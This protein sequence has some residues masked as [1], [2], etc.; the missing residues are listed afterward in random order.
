VYESKL[1]LLGNSPYKEYLTDSTKLSEMFA[2]SKVANVEDHKLTTG[3]HEKSTYKK[4]MA[5]KT[6]FLKTISC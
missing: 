6:L 4:F 1:R 3:A 5:T 2:D